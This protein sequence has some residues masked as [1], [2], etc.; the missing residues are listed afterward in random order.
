MPISRFIRR[1]E[2]CT[3]ALRCACVAIAIAASAGCATS[4]PSSVLIEASAKSSPNEPATRAAAAPPPRVAR[5]PEPLRNAVRAPI[6]SVESRAILVHLIPRGITDREAWAAD[7]HDGLAALQ[8]AHTPENFCAVIA[9][10]EQESSFRADPAVPGL[11]KIAWQEIEKHRERVGAPKMVVQAALKLQSQSGKTYS[12]RL[13][14]VQTERE[15]SELFEEFI[16]RVPMGK[17]LL[18]ERNPVR[19]GGP[20]QVSVTFAEKHVKSR[21]YPYPISD[22][23]RHE[24][25]SRRGGM[26]F[27]MAHLLDYPASYDKNIYRFADYN[28]GQYASRNA[29][30]QS[31][32]ALASGSSLVLDGDVLR[33]DHGQAL[34]QPSSTELAARALS[35]RFGMSAQEMRRDLERATSSDFEQTRLYVRVFALADQMNGRPMPRALIPT[36]LLNSPKFTR[37]L[38]T[39]GYA[40]R[41]DERY[42]KCLARAAELG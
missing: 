10:T 32:L 42:R 38:T 20:M 8:L 16:G 39:S 22:S 19:T 29:A 1:R 7:I 12:E 14:T 18:S 33:Y 23:L 37:K 31:A 9:V 3:D 35:S 27:G 36:I 5:A 6:K 30:F 13:D 11:S 15:L 34:T 2:P 21:K 41:V 17:S 25:F 28:A 4:D 26:Y 40:H 24:V